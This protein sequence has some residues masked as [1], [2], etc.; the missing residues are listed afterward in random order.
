MR[1][2]CADLSSTLHFARFTVSLI[3]LF[4]SPDLHLHKYLVRFR[5]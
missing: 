2:V 5:E 3:F 4:H 1:S